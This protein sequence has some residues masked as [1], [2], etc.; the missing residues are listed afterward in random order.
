MSSVGATSAPRRT[1]TTRLPSEA[2]PVT[3]GE[4]GRGTKSHS[5]RRQSRRY[6]LLLN[7]FAVGY[8]SASAICIASAL[9]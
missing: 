8:I 9:M 3:Q 6:P 2:N 7:A 1:I 5:Q 4:V